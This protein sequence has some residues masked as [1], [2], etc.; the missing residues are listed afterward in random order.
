MPHRAVTGAWVRAERENLGRLGRG[1]TTLL[2][3]LMR[4]SNKKVKKISPDPS[5]PSENTPPSPP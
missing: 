5:E 1:N 2:I 4:G 3:F